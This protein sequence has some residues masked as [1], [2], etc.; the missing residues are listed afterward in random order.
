MPTIAQV[1]ERIQELLEERAD[2]LGRETGFVKRERQLS[3]ADFVQGLVFGLL[4]DPEHSTEELA[5]ILGRRA[6]HIS[7]SGLCQRFTEEAATFLL[8]LL[9]EAVALGLEATDA[10]PVDVL[11]RFEAVVIE[12]SSTIRLPD[13]LADLWQSCGGGQGQSKAGL[14]LHVRWDLKQGGLQGPLLTSSRVADQSS[15]LRQQGIAA[16]VLNITD[17][18]YC[19][20]EWLRRQPGMF[21]SRPRSTVCFLDR[22]TEQVLDLEQI[23]PQAVG[24]SL[25]REVLVGKEAKLPARLIMV[26]VPDDVVEQRQA[27]IR[28]DAKRRGQ[29]QANLQSLARAKWTMLIT[30]VSREKLWVREV[31]VLQRARWQ[32]ERLF[33]LWK[34]YGKIDEWKGRQRWRI[35]CEIYAKVLAMVLQHWVLL[36]GTWHDPSRSLFKA[37]KQVRLHALELFSALAGEG[38]WE[39]VMQRLLQAMQQCRVHRR[40]KH[41]CHAQLL[42]DGLDW[43]VFDECLT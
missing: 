17:E 14:K 13:K 37:A 43:E 30:N 21:L 31:L 41:P 11:A 15:P 35:L 42:L 24:Q 5:T 18:A 39:Q 22:E 6:V 23:G 3:G 32:I 26:R 34:Q 7:A 28:A 1:K 33:R 25:D 10:A 9:E 20:L 38:V 36:L 12:D 8:R 27:R 40:T 4:H 16:G 19:S 2:D 29:G